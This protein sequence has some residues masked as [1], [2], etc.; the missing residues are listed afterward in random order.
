MTRVAA[1]LDVPAAC[2][3]ADISDGEASLPRGQKP[4]PESL[5]GFTTYLLNTAANRVR[6]G[7]QEALMPLGLRPKHH[8]VLA[9]LAAGGPVSQQALGSQLGIDRTTVVAII[10]QLERLRLAER[11]PDREDRRAY[12]LQLTPRGERILEEANRL[13]LQVEAGLLAS[14]TPAERDL[15]NDLMRRIAA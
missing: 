2:E 11:R 10:D 7:V 6:H 8:G 15:L 3:G 12:R 4:L 13:V 1:Q 5:S 9:V 14:L